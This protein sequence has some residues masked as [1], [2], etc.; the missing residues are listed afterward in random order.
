[1]GNLLEKVLQCFNVL[2][3]LSTDWVGY[4]SWNHHGS[5]T[6]RPMILHP[7][8]LGVLVSFY[9]CW[10]EGSWSFIGIPQ[11]YHQE[12]SEDLQ[13]HLDSTWITWIPLVSF[14]SSEGMVRTWTHAIHIH[15]GTLQGRTGR[16]EVDHPLDPVGQYVYLSHSE[17]KPWLRGVKAVKERKVAFQAAM[18]ST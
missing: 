13:V 11:L 15:H 6:V 16:T 9:D 17:Q 4:T 1:M 7:L 18:P 3:V 14:G 2:R 5:G 8:L 10:R 12:R